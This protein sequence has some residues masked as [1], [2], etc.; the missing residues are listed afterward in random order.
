MSNEELVKRIQAGENR[1]D[2][3][4]KLYQK[5]IPYIS[6]IISKY[7]GIGM[8]ENDDLMQEAYFGLAAAAEHYKPDKDIKFM[9]YARIWIHQAL[10]RYINSFGHS[11]RL[12][13]WKLNQIRKYQQIEQELEKAGKENS[14]EIIAEIMGIPPEQADKIKRESVL[15]SLRSTDETINENEEITIID[16]IQDEENQIDNLI[17]DIQHE[18]LKQEIINLIEQLP[19][20]QADII[21]KRYYKNYSLK[22]CSTLLKISPEAARQREIKAILNLKKPKRKNRLKPYLEDRYIS[23]AYTSG[24]LQSYIR[25]W[26]SVEEKIILDK[27]ERESSRKFENY[28][29][30]NS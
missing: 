16:L 2:N 12:P 17:D 6:L 11:V 25:T 3:F 5:N 29:D 19:P 23:M 28:L 24:G 1:K 9:A 18:E 26:T 8:I 13:E 21:K 30:V 27:E 7:R 15:L 22:E 20:E 10:R 14:A 4:E